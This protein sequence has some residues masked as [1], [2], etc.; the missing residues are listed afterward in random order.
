MR[1]VDRIVDRWIL[2]FVAVCLLIDVITRK[3]AA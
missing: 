2:F 3:D 1:I